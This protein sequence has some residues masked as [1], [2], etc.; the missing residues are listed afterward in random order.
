[1][2]L[3]LARRGSQRCGG[4]FSGTVRRAAGEEEAEHR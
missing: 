2:R 4:R 3:P 1:L